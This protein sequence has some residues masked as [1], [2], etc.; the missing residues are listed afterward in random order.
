MQQEYQDLNSGLTILQHGLDVWS[1]FETM[2][3]YLDSSN[4]S[5]YKHPLPKWILDYRH[6]LLEAARPHLENIKNYLIYHDCGKPFCLV[7][8]KE[9]R[10]H[11]PNH[12]DI[13]KQKFLMYSNNQMIADLIGKDMLCHLTKPKDYKL[14]LDEPYIEILLLAGIASIHANAEMFG[15]F[16]SD[17]FKI[18]FKHLDKL[19][20]RILDAEY[21]S[22]IAANEYL[23][24][25]KQLY[26]GAM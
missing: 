17:S 24:K 23:N 12:A 22:S 16:Q 6:N 3:Q 14:L 19:G 21:K 26:K 20:S 1:K 8:D 13:S 11:F 18:K 9:G 7:T 4:T 2:Y 15:G 25:T 10:R 5:A